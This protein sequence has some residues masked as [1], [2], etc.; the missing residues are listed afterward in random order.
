VPT[1][2]DPWIADSSSPS[3]LNRLAIR[4]LGFSLVGQAC[5]FVVSLATTVILARLLT[6]RDFGLVAMVSSV[7]GLI[8]VF[9]DAGLSTATI[10]HATITHAQIST[11]FWLNAALGL[12]SSVVIVAI[13][14]AIAWFFG[15][16]E[17]TWVT[18]GL[19]GVSLLSGLTVQHQTVLQR[20]MRF[21]ALG[22]V[23][24]ASGLV[25]LAAGSIA[26]LAGWRVWSLVTMSLTEAALL[27]GLVWVV[28]GWR[29][30]LPVRRSGVLKLVRFGG[31][32][33]LRDLMAVLSLSVD[34]FLLGRLF[35]P[36]DLGIYT[37]AHA[38][39][40]RP[41][42]QVIPALQAVALPFFSR[43]Q[44]DD[45]RYRSAVLRSL[46]AAS[47][48]SSFGAALTLATSDWIVAIM[49]GDKWVEVSGIFRFFAISVFTA[50]VNAVLSWVLITQR[51][52]K[53]FLRWGM[54]N[55]SLLI[56]SI[57]CA[58]PLG[59]KAVA[60]S[61]SLSGL[62]LRTPLLYYMVGRCSPLRTAELAHV[63]IPG[64]T[65]GTAAVALI[66]GLRMVAGD[67][68]PWFGMF[69]ATAVLLAYYFLVGV[70]TAWGRTSFTVMRTMVRKGVGTDA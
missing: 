27:C 48:V 50:P 37:R 52:G 14:P 26:A 53:D 61:Y 58:A 10:V 25:G 68:T 63:L 13:A 54:M 11:L 69:G 46:Q 36:Q 66:A 64:L 30:S 24:I 70:V 44:T 23:Q 32:V 1:G 34:R 51:R 60:L 43:L 33:A 38:L 5:R 62:F 12:L 28:S 45:E 16:A 57:A 18:M 22:G 47:F 20:Q 41:L 35:G 67:V 55:D 39:L 59:P 31:A 6:P 8:S 65:A 40:L 19:A 9:R 17:L 15:E 42:T 4:G 21:A 2:R 56:A 49:L 7:T 29:P 3:G